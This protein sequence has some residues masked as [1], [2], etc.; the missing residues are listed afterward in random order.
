MIE[1]I[2][3]VITLLA[4]IIFLSYRRGFKNAESKN[5]KKILQS[6]KESKKRKAA[7][8]NDDISIVKQRLRK[9]SREG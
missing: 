2:I 5:N 1:K 4:S 7:R 9:D 6:A 3:A 8:A